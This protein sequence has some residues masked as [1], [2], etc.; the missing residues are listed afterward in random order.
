MNQHLL[1]VLVNN[2]PGLLSKVSGLFSRRGFNIESLAVGVCEKPG[3][4]RMTIVVNGDERVVDQVMKQLDKLI[5][6]LEIERL[7]TEEAV[8]RELI[9]VKVRADIHQRQD[10][11][12]IAEIFRAR[13]VDVA[14]L[15]L[16]LELTGTDDKLSALISLLEPYGIEQIM[17]TGLVAVRRF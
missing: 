14:A 4:S 6:V 15:G 16:T 12:Q 9:L 2:H 8:Q 11:I 13:I 17:R 3:C 1:S 5:D 10:V 7:P